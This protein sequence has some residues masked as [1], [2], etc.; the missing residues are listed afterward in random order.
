MGAGTHVETESSCPGVKPT[1]PHVPSLVYAGTTVSLFYRGLA[2][3]NT[4]IPFVWNN[5]FGRLEISVSQIRPT[6]PFLMGRKTSAK[7][8]LCLGSTK[9]R[10][11]NIYE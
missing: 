10:A 6:A 11:Q 4:L 7:F 1:L 2:S 9:F 3:K 8:G 5:C